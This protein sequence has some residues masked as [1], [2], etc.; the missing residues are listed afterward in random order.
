[1][2]L[3]EGQLLEHR[4]VNL[5]YARCLPRLQTHDDLNR[6]VFQALSA[7]GNDVTGAAENPFWCVR[8]GWDTKGIKC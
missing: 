4:C 5:H 6:L 3:I 1:M 7:W 8:H 2:V